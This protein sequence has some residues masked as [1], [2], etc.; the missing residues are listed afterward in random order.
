MV[1]PTMAD[2]T[3]TLR[4]DLALDAPADRP[5][6]PEMAAFLAAIDPAGARS[7]GLR[8]LYHA[9]V[10][11]DPVRDVLHRE[12][13]LEALAAWVRRGGRVPATLG[14]L[15]GEPMPVVRVRWL[16]EALERFP[17]LGLR[18]AA[19]VATCL[20]AATAD[21]FL[22]RTG[23]PGDRGLFQETLD[24]LSRGLMPQPVDEADI[25][26]LV[27]R[28]FPHKRD[29]LW[30]RLLPPA[31]V[32][33][34]VDALDPASTA[35]GTWSPLRASALD[36]ILLLAS[37]VS[38]A[39]LSDDIRARSPATT[40]QASPFFRLPR[41][42]DALMA[43]RRADHDAVESF[44][45]AC[46]AGIAECRAACAA[47]LDHLEQ[48]GVSVDVVYRLDLIARSLN[49][50]D[51][52]LSVLVPR[53][54]RVTAE[55]VTKLLALLL[56]ERHRASSLRDIVGTNTYLL[57]RKVIE[58]AGITGEHY[59]TVTPGQY[60]WMVLS[61]VGGGAVMG[62][63]TL[64]KFL[65]VRL[66]RAPFQEGL[67]ASL[68]YGGSFLLVQFLGATIATKQASMT[69]A[70]IAQTMHEGD[71]DRGALVTVMARLVRSQIAAAVGNVVTVGATAWAIDLWW[72]ARHGAPFLNAE[73]AHGVLAALHPTRSGTVGFA[74]YTGLA[75]WVSSLC[76]GALEN[77]A[78]YRRLPEA[79]AE[80]RVRR[81]VGARATGWASRVFARNIAGVG[82]N[83]SIGLM[84]GMTTVIGRFVG[85]PIDVRHITLSTGQTVFALRA[86]GA[87]ALATPEARYALLGLGCVLVLNLSVSFVLAIAVAMRAREVGFGTA[88]RLFA[89]MFVGFVR[90][91]LRFFLPVERVSEADRA[92]H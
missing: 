5:A 16:V 76:A 61:A 24:R 52:L 18:V 9:L 87:S 31:V 37:R 50:I 11:V 23:I 84:L 39:G 17:A 36:A 67:L 88:L 15:P 28:M 75:L 86:L 48:T 60:G 53:D 69:A 7:P 6:L 92:A 14:A 41:I 77:W 62:F 26:Q 45:E 91:P 29:M 35:P 32:V 64:L 13:A 8:Q 68:N 71:A 58:R 47:V 78:V 21:H 82:G 59:I 90:S 83:V 55:R 4:E 2:A 40:L 3:P 63:T 34:L 49:R 66:H 80:H 19:T 85:V 65:I 38:A 51:V 54:R 70:A 30:I 12:H 42:L 74:M 22:G 56:W 46:H 33:R 25:T 79:I 27:A 1:A 57:A 43:T 72:T 81:I 89:D 73:Y 10:Q 20:R 44:A